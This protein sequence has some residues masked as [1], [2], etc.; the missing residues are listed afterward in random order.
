MRIMEIFVI[1]NAACGIAAFMIARG[2][3][4]KVKQKTREIVY[5]DEEEPPKKELTQ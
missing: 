1:V 4:R 5:N 3:I 2:L